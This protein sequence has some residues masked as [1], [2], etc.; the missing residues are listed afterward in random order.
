MGRIE[1]TRLETEDGLLLEA[2]VRHPDD[3]PRGSAVVCHA[4]PLHGGLMDHKLLAAVR[5]EL[6]AEGLFVVGFHFRGVRRSE[7]SFGGGVQEGLDVRAALDRARGEAEGPMLL[8]GWSFGGRV[9]VRVAVEDERVAALALIAT[10]PRAPGESEIVVPE[11][12]QLEALAGWD[13]PTLLLV[14]DDD[15]YCPVPRMEEFAA[16]FAHPSF[17]VLAGADHYFTGREREAGALVA[18]FA[19]DALFAGSAR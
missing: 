7:G 10:S 15:R 13:H 18:R 12:P 8:C 6:L 16:M 1:R 3:P 5:R 9:A 2:V 19:R 4:H 11:L 14:G 17:H